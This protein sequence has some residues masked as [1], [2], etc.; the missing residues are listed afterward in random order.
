MKKILF[1][2]LCISVLLIACVKK[3]IVLPGNDTSKFTETEDDKLI[4]E[5]VLA[6]NSTIDGSLAAFARYEKQPNEFPLTFKESITRFHHLVFEFD[7]VYPVKEMVIHNEDLVYIHIEYS[8][9][10]QGFTRIKTT[11]LNKGENRISLDGINAYA[12]RLVFPDDKKYTINDVYFTLALGMI[13]KQREDWFN[14]FYQRKGWTGADGI[15]SFNLDGTHHLNNDSEKLFIFSDTFVGELYE[16]AEYRKTMVMINNSVGYLD[17]KKPLGENLTFFYKES[18][19]GAPKTVFTPEAYQ[20]R[21]LRNLLDYDGL[22]P[23]ASK[24]GLLVKDSFG[25]QYLTEGN[26]A[27]FTI[28]LQ[29]VKTLS[30]INIWNYNDEVSFGATE[31]SIYLSNDNLT[32]TLFETTTLALASGSNEEQLTK[33]IELSEEARFVKFLIKNNESK[34]GLGKIYIEDHNLAPLF[35]TIFGKEAVTELNGVENS[36]RLWLQDGLVLNNKFYVY[37]ILVK[38]VPGAFK[39]HSV[40]LIEVPIVNNRLVYEET[41]YLNTPLQ[42]RTDDG[43]EIFYGAG[44]MEHVDKDGY[45]YIYGYKD[46]NGR[47]LTVARYKPEDIKDFNKYEFFDGVSF[48]RDIRKSAPLM[49]G[50]SAE[51]SV[52]YLEEGENKGK[53]MLVSIENTTSGRVVISY[54]DTPY[55]PFSP[56]EMIYQTTEHTYL[57]AFTYNAKMHPS[58]SKP[59]RYIITYNVNSTN[60]N[61]LRNSLIYYPR[62]IELIEVKRKEA[63]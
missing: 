29:A 44:I 45:I 34:I 9:D 43:G 37:P 15:F 19:L 4:V 28:D 57:D 54:S 31:V 23:G 8:F 62:F 46:L 49:K 53:Y 10:K 60:M 51:L 20:G 52:T 48:Q 55:G 59:G 36:S 25:K 21:Q 24:D 33:S 5:S 12:I 40:N 17:P 26:E 13:T 32:Y 2:L 61:S 11:D 50:V 38:D 22:N 14:A 30:S 63:K 41:K 16:E 39:V 35:G 1:I 27:E 6:P 18:L 47:F 42:V 3:E 7:A 56:F 58:I